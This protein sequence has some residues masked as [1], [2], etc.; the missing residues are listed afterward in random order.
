MFKKKDQVWGKDQVRISLFCL[1]AVRL[2]WCLD[3]L[4]TTRGKVL[5]VGCGGG[6]MA[7]AIKF[8]RPD[9]KVF[10]CDIDKK[11][12]EFAKQSAQGVKFTV[13][14]IN[15]LPFEDCQ[16]DAV[17]S[18]DCFE[19]LQTP[20]KSLK[21]AHRTLKHKGVFHNFVP[22]EGQF[23]TFYWLF[24]EL[25]G[26]N[27]KKA[28]AGHYKNYSFQALKKI[29]QNQGFKIRS[30]RFG[31]HYLFQLIDLGYYISWNILKKKPIEKN[32]LFSFKKVLSP[33]TNLES[34]LLSKFPGGGVSISAVKK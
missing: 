33:F 17:V 14:D 32:A 15:F 3:S 31:Y 12:V 23:G 26:W 16:F 30:Y 27:L 8:Y 5:E 6:G 34:L 9:L 24:F 25:L 4:K 13:A 20:E 28:L 11:A 19:H 18:F 22:L 7:K 1:Q 29:L 2:K 10:A 21:E